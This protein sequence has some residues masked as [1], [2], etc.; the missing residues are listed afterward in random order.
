[1]KVLTVCANGMGSSLVLKMTVEKAFKELG[2]KADVNATDLA[3]LNTQKADVVITSPSL[4]KSIQPNEE[5]KLLVVTNFVDTE[6]IKKMLIEKLNI[7][8]D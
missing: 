4:A 3:T 7:K 5:Q 2:V 8:G 1:M 6:S